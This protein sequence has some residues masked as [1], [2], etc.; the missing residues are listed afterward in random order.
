MALRQ[1]PGF[2]RGGERRE[3]SGGRGWLPRR[4][5]GGDDAWRHGLCAGVSCGTTVPRKHVAS[6]RTGQPGIDP[7][8]SGREGSGS[9]EIVLTAI[10][11]GRESGSCGST[12]GGNLHI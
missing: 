11:W 9:A 10:V 8:L 3:I 6:D 4:G 12:H 5:T 7:E 1:W 2:R